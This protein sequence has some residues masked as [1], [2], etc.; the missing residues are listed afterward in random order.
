MEC[1][2]CCSGAEIGQKMVQCAECQYQACCSCVQTYLTT[3]TSDPHC[4]NCRQVWDILFLRKNLEKQF[5]EGVWKEHRKQILSKR[6][7]RHQGK[8]IV[9][10]CPSCP[11]GKIIKSTHTCSSCWVHVCGRCHQQDNDSPQ[12]HKCPEDQIKSLKMITQTTKQCPGCHVPI[13]KKSGCFQMF[14]THCYTA[15]DWKH[16]SVL[17]KTNLHNPHYFDHQNHHSIVGTIHQLINNMTNYSL[18]WV[19]R[20]FSL[21]VQDIGR[22]VQ[23][24]HPSCLYE[25]DLYS[26]DEARQQQM[27]QYLLWVKYYKRGVAILHN[28]VCH[29]ETK[30]VQSQIQCFKHDLKENLMEYN[31]HVADCIQLRGCRLFPCNPPMVCV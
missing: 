24:H 12:Q 3:I 28:M 10:A 8:D 1:G 23:Y 18:K 14:C 31:E 4:M 22:Q 26:G 19:Y 27:C 13:E 15:F 16:G 11:Y 9:C 7:K 29:Q 21:L 5:L 30:P 6:S 25:T 17:E 20:E 2:V